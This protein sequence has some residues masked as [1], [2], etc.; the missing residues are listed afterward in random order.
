MPMVENSKRA[1]NKSIVH[2]VDPSELYSILQNGSWAKA[3]AELCQDKAG[4]EKGLPFELTLVV[5]S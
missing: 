3:E 1:D 4:G 5:I 2:E